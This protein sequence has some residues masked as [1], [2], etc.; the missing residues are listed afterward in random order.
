MDKSIER[1]TM[2]QR[3]AEAQAKVD[4][5]LDG[6]NAGVP[7]STEDNEYGSY[8]AWTVDLTARACELPGMMKDVAIGLVKEKADAVLHQFFPSVSEE[9]RDADVIGLTDV[10]QEIEEADPGLKEALRAEAKEEE[11]A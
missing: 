9:K 4:A 6:L 8:I 3:R 1:K 5:Y 2:A 7:E 11:A 10:L